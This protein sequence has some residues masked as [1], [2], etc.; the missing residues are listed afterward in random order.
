MDAVAAVE[1][2]IDQIRVRWIAYDLVKVDQ[3]VEGRLR[4]DPLIHFIADL[5]LRQVPS[6]I[7]AG[8]GNVMA[9]DDGD[10]DDLQPASL[11][12]LDDVLGFRDPLRGGGATTDVVRAHE[13]DDVCHAIV[14]E[15]VAI[16]PLD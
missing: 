7:R 14:A 11:H 16:E 15:N 4:A 3:G 5:G 8:G 1:W 13:Q 6:R 9:R 10:A 12:P 2:R